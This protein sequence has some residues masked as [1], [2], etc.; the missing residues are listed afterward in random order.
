MLNPYHK[1]RASP[2]NIYTHAYRSTAFFDSNV[3]A[4]NGGAMYLF[5]FQGAI[6]PAALFSNN[7]AQNGAGLYLRSINPPG[8]TVGYGMFYA[9]SNSLPAR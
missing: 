9:M 1:H 2:Q 7:R 3:A 6:G 4:G 8:F 5:K